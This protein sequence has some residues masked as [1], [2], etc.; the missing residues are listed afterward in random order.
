M[1]FGVCGNSCFSVYHSVIRVDVNLNERV[2]TSGTLAIRLHASMGGTTCQSHGATLSW[3]AISRSGFT[4]HIPAEQ[5]WYRHVPRSTFWRWSGNEP[6]YNWA[7][8]SL[9]PKRLVVQDPIVPVGMHRP[10]RVRSPST[11]SMDILQT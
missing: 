9:W 8:Y 6:D 5:L 4:L 1:S 2:W 3:R 10:Y 7:E 11:R